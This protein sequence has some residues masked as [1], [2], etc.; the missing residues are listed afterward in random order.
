MAH[1]IAANNKK[2]KRTCN[3]RGDYDTTY[4]QSFNSSFTFDQVN[5]LKNAKKREKKEA[6]FTFRTY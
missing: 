6:A 3:D 1:L 4:V 5:S 2:A